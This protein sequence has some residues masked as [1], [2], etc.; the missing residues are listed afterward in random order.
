MSFFVALHTES[1]LY[2]DRL[3]ATRAKSHQILG[4]I[5]SQLTSRLNM[6]DLQ[7]LDRAARL[8]APAVAL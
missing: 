8:A 2:M 1:A 4:D 5:I 7:P 6:M 3:V